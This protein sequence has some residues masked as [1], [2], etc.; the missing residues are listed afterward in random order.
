MNRD[1]ATPDARCPDCG[2]GWRLRPPPL[3]GFWPVEVRCRGPH[4]RRRHW[5]VIVRTG[6]VASFRWSV[7]RIVESSGPSPE[8]QRK[9]LLR[10]PELNEDLVE[11]AILVMHT[12]SEKAG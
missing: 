7:V 8:D 1:D 12:Q 11:L 5:F 6:L 2:H 9:T 10:V 3:V 4:C